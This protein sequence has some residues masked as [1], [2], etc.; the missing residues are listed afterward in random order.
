MLEGEASRPAYEG[1]IEALGRRHADDGVRHIREHL[2]QQIRE[3]IAKGSF[4]V[5]SNIQRGAGNLT[6][7]K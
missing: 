5:V 7:E 2:E 1:P 3:N 4:G 6:D